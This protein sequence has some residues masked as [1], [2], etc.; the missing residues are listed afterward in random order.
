MECIWKGR[1]TQIDEQLWK[2]HEDINKLESAILE[3]GLLNIEIWDNHQSL[4]F[5]ELNSQKF[6]NQLVNP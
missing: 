6:Y 2:R 4:K 3:T 5:I 1:V